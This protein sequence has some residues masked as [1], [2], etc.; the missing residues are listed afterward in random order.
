MYQWGLS[1]DVPIAGDFDG[2]GKSELAVYRPSIGGW[3]IRNSSQGYSTA[4][5]SFY[6]WGL[7]GDVPIAADFDGDGKTDLTVFRPPT[8]E[9]FIRYSAQGY[10]ANTAGVYQW[11]LPG[12]VPLSSDFDGDGKTELAVFRPSIGGWFIRYSSRGLLH[13]HR[14]LLP[15][16]PA[17]RCADRGRF[18]R[19]RQ[20][21]ARGLPA[22]DRRVVHPLLLAKLRRQ[23]CWRVSVGAGGGH[24][25][26]AVG[27]RTRWDGLRKSLTWRCRPPTVFCARPGHHCCLH[28]NDALVYWRLAQRSSSP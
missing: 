3:F 9:W 4:T 6:Q 18:R 21:R 1:G 26:Q 20:D 28:T 16:G 22:G 24:P 10:D 14:E 8:G 5:A 25:G 23:H 7:P 19:G 12:D 27:R 13:R 11:G 15:V 2:D 17:G